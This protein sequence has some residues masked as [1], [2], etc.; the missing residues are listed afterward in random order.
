MKRV[1]LIIACILVFCVTE[2]H[3]QQPAP[4]TV[5]TQAPA[6]ST[7][8][9]PK[10][11][12]VP[13]S[14]RVGGFT[15]F[16]PRPIKEKAERL[17]SN[18]G[19][20][21][22]YICEAETADAHYQVSALYLPE[23]EATP[24]KAIAKF[25][26]QIK[27]V[28]SD[29]QIKWISGGS[30]APDGNPGVEIKATAVADGKMIW[31]RQ[32]F[33]FGRIY[34]TTVRT[35]IKDVDEKVLATFLDSFKVVFSPRVMV[36]FPIELFAGKTTSEDYWLPDIE[37]VSGKLL[38]QNL[39]KRDMPKIPKEVKGLTTSVLVHVVVSAEGR[40][41]SA[42]ALGGNGLL[43]QACAEAVQQWVFV[44]LQVNGAPAKVQGVI[45]FNF[46]P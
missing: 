29:P 8:V 14:P 13:F 11:I 25:A 19:V 20:S 2:N 7:T 44:P 10:P 4:A 22:M 31:S 6:A 23:S 39:L 42:K 32:Y 1:H 46:T 3:A 30:I 43:G 33:A 5:P 38:V 12:F 41:L 16:L 27:Q 17:S 24:D 21:Y 15:V 26:A 34:E 37:K 36:E 18:N 40:V 45:T 28:K 35:R 9:I